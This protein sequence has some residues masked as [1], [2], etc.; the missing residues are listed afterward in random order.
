MKKIQISATV[1]LIPR[2]RKVFDFV[3]SKMEDFRSWFRGSVVPFLY[4]QV[5]KI[6]RYEYKCDRVYI[7]GLG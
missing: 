5:F 1:I 6:H 7:P 2:L 3:T 4:V